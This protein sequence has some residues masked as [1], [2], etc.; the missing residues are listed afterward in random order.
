MSTLTFAALKTRFAKQSATA[1]ESPVTAP[2][3][4]PATESPVTVATAQKIVSLLNGKAVDESGVAAF[5]HPAMADEHL[6]TGYAGREVTYGELKLRLSSV[7]RRNGTVGAHYPVVYSLSEAQA[8]S[9]RQYLTTLGQSRPKGGSG[10]KK[11]AAT[12]PVAAPATP[13]APVQP[14][15]LAADVAMLKDGLLAVFEL[16]ADRESATPTPGHTMAEPVAAAT[17]PVA[18]IKL[19]VGQV[20][21]IDGELRRV[22]QTASG[23]RLN[24]TIV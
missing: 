17:P 18:A 8:V 7:E 11:A 12:P 4:V 6:P 2:V 22:V 21:D 3:T 9:I 1:T 14:E 23:L 5:I 24:K 13:V 10:R 15:G 16:L 20:V 19:A